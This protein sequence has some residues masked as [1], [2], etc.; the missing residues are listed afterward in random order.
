MADGLGE[1]RDRPVVVEVGEIRE[2]LGELRVQAGR[3]C[4]GRRAAR[5]RHVG[6]REIL[7]GELHV[8]D[9]RVERAG[10]RLALSPHRF[11]AGDV[12]RAVRLLHG[13]RYRG[14]VHV[15]C[16]RIEW[17]KKRLIHRARVS[18]GGRIRVT[19][20]VVRAAGHVLAERLRADAVTDHRVQLGAER[21]DRL[22]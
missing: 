22:G 13:E 7:R 17:R 12:V 3:R 18:A 11:D 15:D 1:E 5:L 16:V 6:V 21:A 20:R 14:S 8:G 4:G 19:D 2:R 10:D 9:R